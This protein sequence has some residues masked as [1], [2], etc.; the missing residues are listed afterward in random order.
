MSKRR[1]SGSIKG[2]RGAASEAQIGTIACQG[3]VAK[4]SGKAS[5]TTKTAAQAKNMKKRETARAAKKKRNEHAHQTR[6]QNSKREK[7]YGS[8][9]TKHRR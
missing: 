4:A 3:K 8:C 1:A 7:W 6:E 2:K 5:N 9:L